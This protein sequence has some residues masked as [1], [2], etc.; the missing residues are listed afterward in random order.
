MELRWKERSYEANHKLSV[1]NSEDSND[2][3]TPAY[4]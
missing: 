4:I 2:Y 3:M 1:W